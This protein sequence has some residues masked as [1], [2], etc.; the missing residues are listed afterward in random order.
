MR[1]DAVF[2]SGM[3]RRHTSWLRIP[4]QYT[5]AQRAPQSSER[6]EL[7]STFCIERRGEANRLTCR[8]RFFGVAQRPVITLE[9]GN[10]RALVATAHRY[11]QLRVMR[12]LFRQSLRF[13][14]TEINSHLAHDGYDFGMHPLARCRPGRYGFLFRAIGEVVEEGRRHLRPPGVVNAGEDYSVDVTS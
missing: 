11:Q 4:G 5:W 13:G 10:I 8:S 7:S 6:R 3:E 14:G 12:Q 1:S 2:G 9:A